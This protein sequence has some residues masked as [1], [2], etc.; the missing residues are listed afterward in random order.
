MELQKLCI[1]YMQ[2]TSVNKPQ[3]GESILLSAAH[4]TMEGERIDLFATSG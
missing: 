1:Q 2:R 4:T 3:R